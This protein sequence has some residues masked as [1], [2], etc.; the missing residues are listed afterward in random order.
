MLP[1]DV[2]FGTGK[3]PSHERYNA[4]HRFRLTAARRSQISGKTSVFTKPDH[5]PIMR[6][7]SDRLFFHRDRM[8]SKV[9]G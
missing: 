1:P 5:F 3:A 4:A 9:G 6:R 8:I 2:S 7:S